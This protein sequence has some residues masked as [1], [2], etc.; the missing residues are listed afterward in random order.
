MKFKSYR[1]LLTEINKV[2]PVMLRISLWTYSS[3]RMSYRVS[4]DQ[5]QKYL[6]ADLLFDDH[7][8]DILKF[9][10]VRGEKRKFHMNKLKIAKVD[11]VEMEG[12]A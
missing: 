8:H 1:Q 5:L 4:F 9:E 12:I 6:D 3:G 7:Y 2:K 10:D 11:Y